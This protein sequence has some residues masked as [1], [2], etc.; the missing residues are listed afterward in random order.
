MLWYFQ[1]YLPETKA[2]G[3][4]VAGTR[5]GWATQQARNLLGKALMLFGEWLD[6]LFSLIHKQSHAQKPCPQIASQTLIIPRSFVKCFESCPNKISLN[7]KLKKE[8]FSQNNANENS[9][10]LWLLYQMGKMKR[11]DNSHGWRGG[12]RWAGISHTRLREH[13]SITSFWRAVQY[14]SLTALGLSICFDSHFTLEN[15]FIG[16]NLEYASKWSPKGAMGFWHAGSCQ[17][18]ILRTVPP[19]G[20]QLLEISHRGMGIFTLQKWTSTANQG[21][22]LP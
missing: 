15:L 8:L 11:H 3:W 13:A 16:K 21:L 17:H 14:C 10:E 20:L 1:A 18:W 22:S 9:N 2:R 4:G 19:W 6:L 5:W 12:V 7:Y